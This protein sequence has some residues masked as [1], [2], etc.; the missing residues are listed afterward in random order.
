M[1]EHVTRQTERSHFAPAKG[2]PRWSVAVWALGTAVL[3][4]LDRRAAL[5]FALGGGIGVGLFLVQGSLAGLWAGPRG[6]RRAR[7]WLWAILAVKWPLVGTALYLAL[8]AGLAA[9]LWIC[10][11]AGLVPGVATMLCLAGIVRDRFRGAAS[12]EVGP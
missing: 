3:L 11:G 4:I 10:V 8:R 2:T 6:R 5:G 12:L 1:T 9:P 7:L